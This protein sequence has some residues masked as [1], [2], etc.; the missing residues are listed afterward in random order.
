MSILT[1]SI[2]NELEK[3]INSQVKNHDAENKSAVVRNALRMYREEIE[4]REI[5][6]AS[7]EVKEGK[8]LQGDLRELAKRFK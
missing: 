4:I 5:L 8:A 2:D 1:L 3:F 6:A 7:R